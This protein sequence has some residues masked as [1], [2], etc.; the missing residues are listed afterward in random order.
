REARVLADL[1]LP[2][3]TVA[4][5]V[6]I[7]RPAFESSAV[8][9]DRSLDLLGEITRDDTGGRSVEAIAGKDG[10][11]VLVEI[12]Q[13]REHRLGCDDN[14][15]ALVIAK[16][17]ALHRRLRTLTYFHNSVLSK[18]AMSA[19]IAC[20]NVHL[21]ELARYGVVEGSVELMV[22]RGRRRRGGWRRFAS[23]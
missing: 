3:L 8:L 13:L 12:P 4:F 7:A 20:Q 15:L 22:T 14:R 6:A 11:D 17:V 1:H 18:L 9:D 16:N 10:S 2:L 5:Q 19:R 23:R 21:R